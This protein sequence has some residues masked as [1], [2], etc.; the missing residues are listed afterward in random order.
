[1][2]RLVAFLILWRFPSK[3]LTVSVFHRAEVIIIKLLQKSS[4]PSELQSL[5]CAGAEATIRNK[6][7]S[8][9]HQLDPILDCEGLIR[10]GGRLGR[11]AMDVN[12]KHPILLPRQSQVTKLIIGWCHENVQ[13]GGRGMTLNEL[14]KNG[15]W[16]INGNFQVRFFI[17]K[18][19]K[20]I[21]LRGRVQQQKMADL[22]TDRTQEAPPFTYCAVDMFGPF[23]IK[24]GRKEMK[25]YVALFTCLASRAAHL[26]STNTMDTDSFIQ[27]LRRFI[28]RRGPIRTIRCDNG[29]NFVGAKNELQKSMKELDQDTITNFLLSLGADWMISWCHNPPAASHF[30][31]VWE[32]QIRAARSILSSLMMTHGHSLN[33]ESFRTLLTEVEPITNSRPLTVETIDDVSS[34]VPL[35]PMNLLTAKSNVVLPPPGIFQ[36]AD[37]YCRRRWRRVQHICNEFW[38]RGGKSTFKVYR[39]D[40]SGN[41]SSEM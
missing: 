1:M 4:F 33:D 23:I 19:V 21:K 27:C 18:C 29:T 41:N 30:G 28:G 24:E 17:M 16:V 25:R 11:S 14:S 15:F 31:G 38:S 13:H 8:K 40:R 26:E 37:L 6:K 3:L 5:S 36:K 32:R 39:Q 22:P 12:E 20:C 9:L 10:V 2:K 34:P 35:S 7:T